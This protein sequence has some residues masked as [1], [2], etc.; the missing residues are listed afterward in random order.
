MDRGAEDP[1]PT[2]T[3][4]P[5]LVELGPYGARDEQQE[6]QSYAASGFH[7]RRALGLQVICH[8]VSPFEI[9]GSIVKY[10]MTRL[11]LH[12]ACK[13]IQ[14]LTINILSDIICALK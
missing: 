5:P 11:E 8:W 6:H 7:M 4:F 12:F 14:D 3:Y 10:T 9:A 13:Y 2:R 1:T